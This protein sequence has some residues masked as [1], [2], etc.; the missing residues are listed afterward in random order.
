VYDEKKGRL[1]TTTCVTLFAEPVKSNR[2]LSA[3]L[4][5]AVLSTQSERIA[6]SSALA[7][8]IEK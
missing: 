4:K 7:E 8:S 5:K 1:K 6:K 3:A 2:V